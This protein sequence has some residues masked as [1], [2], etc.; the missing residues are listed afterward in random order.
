MPR[1]KTASIEIGFE[2]QVQHEGDRCERAILNRLY[3]APTR[4][5]DLDTLGFPK[6]LTNRVLNSLL[7][8]ERVVSHG[9]TYFYHH[10]RSLKDLS[11][12][13]R[14]KSNGL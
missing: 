2:E 14:S 6:P 10:L 3:A 12:T 11:P 5:E 13:E 8:R 9:F 4:M 7:H 1:P